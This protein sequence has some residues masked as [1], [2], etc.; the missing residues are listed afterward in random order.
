MHQKTALLRYGGLVRKRGDQIRTLLRGLETMRKPPVYI[1]GLPRSGTTWIA[2]IVAT[3]RSVKYFHEPFNCSNVAGAARFCMKYLV[4][5]DDDPDFARHCRKAFAG[6]IL[7]DSMRTMLPPFYR[8]YPKLP[9]R[10]I[11]KDVCT[12]LAVECVQS[13]LNPLT[14]IVVRHPCA[15]AASWHRLGY[16]VDHHLRILRERNGLYDGVLEPYRDILNRATGFW[17]KIGALWGAVYCILYHQRKAHANWV[18]VNHEEF[19]R[20]PIDAF[21]NL[22]RRLDLDWTRTTGELIRISSQT[23]RDEPYLFYRISEQE[24]EKWKTRMTV[25]QM[26]QVLDF[27]KPFGILSNADS[28]DGKTGQERNFE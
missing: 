13:L 24:P 8:H 27:V 21:R 14:V 4:N 16:N 19:C 15:V 28:S 1:V 9:G 12:C 23:D 11:V 17:Q 26:S 25:D 10:V 3:A 22:F 20:K 2:S 6:E 18:V 7:T 5:A